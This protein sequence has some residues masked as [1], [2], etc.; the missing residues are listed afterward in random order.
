MERLDALHAGAPASGRGREVV[1]ERR[2]RSR[3]LPAHLL[4]TR[5]SR[6]RELL[7][8]SRYSDTALQ[9]AAHRPF[10]RRGSPTRPPCRTHSDPSPR[11]ALIP[12]ASCAGRSAAEILLCLL[13]CD[14]SSRRCA[15]PGAGPAR[16]SGRTSSL[17]GRRRLLRCARLR[18][19]SLCDSCSVELALSLSLRRSQ[20]VDMPLWRS[21]ALEK[22][23]TRTKRSRRYRARSTL[24]DAPKLQR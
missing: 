18:S 22:R 3:L 10:R 20:A 23:T 19:C 16:A 8:C 4:Q 1:V 12:L 7:S 5:S 17:A 15:L 13:H 24:Q 11:C 2:R 9:C 21:H 14:T 6:C